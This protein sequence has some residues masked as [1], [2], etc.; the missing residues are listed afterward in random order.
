MENHEANDFLSFV[1]RVH[2]NLVDAVAKLGNRSR[3]KDYIC[4]DGDDMLEIEFMR[5]AAH[6][7][8]CTPFHPEFILGYYVSL[9]TLLTKINVMKCCL[10][11][12][13]SCDMLTVYSDPEC[14]NRLSEGILA[15]IMAFRHANPNGTIRLF[16][17]NTFNGRLHKY[18]YSKLSQKIINHNGEF[19]DGLIRSYPSSQIK[20]L[21]RNLLQSFWGEGGYPPVYIAIA[22][23]D[24]KHLDWA[25]EL[26]FKQGK[27]PLNQGAA[28]GKYLFHL[29]H[30]GDLD[31]KLV[32]IK[33]LMDMSSEM[34]LFHELE[35]NGYNFEDI[36]FDLIVELYLWLVY[37]NKPIRFVSWID[38]E[39]PKYTDISWALTDKERVQ[40]HKAQS[41][42]ER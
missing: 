35:A 9:R 24:A 11:I 3:P 27:V 1:Q 21:N 18:T 20:D 7:L 41:S 29:A 17:K 33:N 5:M 16:D 12:A 37:F 28:F 23:R 31:S 32:D 38:A 40:I 8:K 13:T 34:W 10:S 14:I 25:R 6:K 4:F 42:K 15:E 22:S 2:P 30:S 19:W 26:A 39:V 36:P